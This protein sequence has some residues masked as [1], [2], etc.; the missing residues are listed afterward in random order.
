MENSAK[1][2][3]YFFR[4][5]LSYSSSVEKHVQFVNCGIRLAFVSHFNAISKLSFPA[6]WA[7]IDNCTVGTH[8]CQNRICRVFNSNTINPY[9]TFVKLTCRM[10]QNH[11]FIW[12]AWGRYVQVVIYIPIMGVWIW[13]AWRLKS[14]S[15]SVEVSCTRYCLK[16]KNDL[17]DHMIIPCNYVA[18]RKSPSQQIGSKKVE[19]RHLRWVLHCGAISG[20]D[21]MGWMGWISGW[22]E[23]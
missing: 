10:F 7:A 2:Y 12:A 8:F 6:N 21:G 1:S 11:C 22:G 3:M 20:Q 4:D 15:D 14:T 5:V 13:E 17:E 16:K 18:V 19:K 23:V 9:F